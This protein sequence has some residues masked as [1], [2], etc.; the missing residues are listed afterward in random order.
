MRI[1]AFSN[2]ASNDFVQLNSLYRLLFKFLDWDFS[3]GFD[4]TIAPVQVSGVLSTIEFVSFVTI[5]TR[6]TT[7]NQKVVGFSKLVN[8]R[9]EAHHLCSAY[10]STNWG[11]SC[12]KN[13]TKIKIDLRAHHLAGLSQST[14]NNA[15]F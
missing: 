6:S 3:H 15:F 5:T 13:A 9:N 7:H 8:R 14:L 1:I 2:T 11:P 4:L 10:G 12:V